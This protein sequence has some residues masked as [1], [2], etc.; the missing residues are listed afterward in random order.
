MQIVSRNGHFIV[1]A[2]NNANT[3]FFSEAD[4]DTVVEVMLTVV[5][6]HEVTL[7]DVAHT[8]AYDCFPS[9][10]HGLNLNAKKL[11]CTLSTLKRD[12]Y[13]S[14]PHLHNATSLLPVLANQIKL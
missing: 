13:F 6:G 10:S 7:S 2:P 12:Y 9:D 4:H 14:V 1:S 8:V 5:E 11:N 3:G